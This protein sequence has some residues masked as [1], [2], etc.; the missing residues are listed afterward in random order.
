MSVQLHIANSRQHLTITCRA[1]TG[2]GARSA[3]DSGLHDVINHDAC[4]LRLAKIGASDA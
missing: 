2:H 4:R 3:S 1:S